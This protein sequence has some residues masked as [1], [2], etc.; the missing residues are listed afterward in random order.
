M[1]FDVNTVSTATIAYSVTNSVACRVPPSVNALSAR[2]SNTP[3]S[4]RH[5]DRNVIDRNSAS[6]FTGFTAVSATRFC[7]T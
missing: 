1:S 7:A 6:I 5:T 3:S 2:Y 4:S